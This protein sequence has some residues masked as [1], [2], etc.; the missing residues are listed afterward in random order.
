MRTVKEVDLSPLRLCNH[1]EVLEL[2]KNQIEKIGLTPL[3]Y[4][5]TIRR[6]RVRE[7]RLQSIDLWPLINANSLEE[8]DLCGSAP[9]YTTDGSTTV[10]QLNSFSGGGGGT[11]EPSAGSGA[12]PGMELFGF[13]VVAAAGLE[14][15]LVLRKR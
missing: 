11:G 1:L 6:I 15:L 2:S 10:I 3:E 14:I 13:I 5:S 7:N 8:I 9:C 4:C 12:A